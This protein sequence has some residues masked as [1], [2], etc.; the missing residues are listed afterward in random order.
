MIKKGIPH[1]FPKPTPRIAGFFVL[2]YEDK[3]EIDLLEELCFSRLA[4]YLFQLERLFYF[5]R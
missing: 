4:K 2:C 5:E 3:S 1:G